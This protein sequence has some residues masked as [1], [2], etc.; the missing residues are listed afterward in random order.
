[1]RVGAWCA[2]VLVCRSDPVGQCRA[3]HRAL[4]KLMTSAVQLVIWKSSMSGRADASQDW[5]WQQGP[6]QVVTLSCCRPWHLAKLQL[7]RASC[8]DTYMGEAGPKL[9]LVAL[10]G[11]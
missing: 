8:C 3:W 11:Q 1:M 5:F 10:Q 6:A 4:F 2:S 7:A 9:S